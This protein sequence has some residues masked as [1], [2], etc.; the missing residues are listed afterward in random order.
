[1]KTDSEVPVIAAASAVGE[2]KVQVQWRGGPRAGETEV[3]DLAPMVL[4]FRIYAPLR[5]DRELFEGVRVADEGRSLVWGPDD[6]IDLS[7]DALLDLAQQ[8]VL[9]AAAARTFG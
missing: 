1:M 6:A 3:V 2:W 8:A 7:A 5:G 4:R 9:D